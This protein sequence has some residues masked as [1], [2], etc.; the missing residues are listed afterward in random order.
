MAR[1]VALF[2]IS[3]LR[4]PEETSGKKHSPTTEEVIVDMHMPYLDDLRR[5]GAHC[6]FLDELHAKFIIVDG[7]KGLLMSANYSRNS[8]DRNIETGILLKADETKEME[9]VFDKLYTNA[10]I[11]SFEYHK[12]KKRVRR[13]TNLIPEDTFDCINS[14][15]RL[16]ISSP[17]TYK[18]KART[19]LAECHVTTIY[20]SIV[21]IINRAKVFV[22]I[23]TWH[24]RS[25][26]LLPDF[27]K[28]IQNAQKRNVKVYLYSNSY[29]E[30]QSLNDSLMAIKQLE[31]MGCESHGDDN[32]HSKCVINEEEGII[33]TAN[34]DG[35]HGMTTGFEVGCMLDKDQHFVVLNHVVSLVN[36]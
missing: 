17:E 35:V 21:S 23:V 5:N 7:E 34:I 12:D 14:N 29:G 18:R 10:D 4:D 20:E 11:Q 32:N 31:E 27:L 24:F 8:L 15:L 28:A 6:H 9:Y 19:N 2:V 25:L 1:G 30:S 33:F 36:R 16:T 26:E 13:N 3:N 22:F